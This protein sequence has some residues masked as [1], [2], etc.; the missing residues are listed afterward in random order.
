M[1]AA[2]RADVTWNMW[3]VYINCAYCV[4]KDN[5]FKK[6]II[7]NIVGAAPAARDISDVAFVW[8]N[9]HSIKNFDESGIENSESRTRLGTSK[10][11]GSLNSQ[12]KDL[13]PY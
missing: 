7:G 2:R 6:F 4:L 13:K 5:T 3:D 11:Q 1:E 8:H 12:D 9:I 10:L